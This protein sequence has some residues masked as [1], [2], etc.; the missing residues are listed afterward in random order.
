MDWAWI[1]WLCYTGVNDYVFN[2]AK[3]NSYVL[4]PAAIVA[5]YWFQSYA[6]NSEAKWDDKVA[7]ALRKRFGI[8]DDPTTSGGTPA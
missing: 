2:L 4:G 6:K 3:N 5:W 8:K 1:E 7:A